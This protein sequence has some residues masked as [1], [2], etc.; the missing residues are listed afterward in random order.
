MKILSVT[1][2]KLIDP[3]V[4]WKFVKNEFDIGT[5]V[6]CMKCSE[7]FDISGWLPIP[8]S[9]ARSFGDQC[10]LCKE[11]LVPYLSSGFVLSI[12]KDFPPF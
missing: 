11:E 4:G 1:H 6:A 7:G 9:E 10:L 5:D 2:L 12:Q 3:Q 8:Q